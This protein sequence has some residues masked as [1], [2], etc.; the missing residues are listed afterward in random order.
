MRPGPVSAV[1]L[2][3]LQADLFSFVRRTLF[4]TSK[5]FGLVFCL[6]ATETEPEPQTL[7]GPADL[8]RG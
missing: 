2:L 7:A 8:Q 5:A 1:C 6:Q 4:F 3:L